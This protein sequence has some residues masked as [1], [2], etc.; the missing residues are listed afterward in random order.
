MMKLR[1]I[2]L[3]VI[4]ALGI[5]SCGTAGSTEMDPAAVMDAYTAAINSGDVEAALALVADD[6]VYERPAGTFNGKA[7]IRGFIEDL[8]ARNAQVQLI[9]ERQVNGEVVSWQSL[10]TIDDPENPGTRLELRNNSSS[11]IRNGLIVHHQAQPAAQ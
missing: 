5:V 1:V 3:L 9:G 10:V 4:L 2:G 8:I 7:E 11:T 6:A